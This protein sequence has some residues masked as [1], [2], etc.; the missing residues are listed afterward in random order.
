M[1]CHAMPCPPMVVLPWQRMGSGLGPGIPR[2]LA[3]PPP[4]S[5]RAPYHVR[6]KVALVSDLQAA[7]GS[8][9]LLGCCR[10]ST[11]GIRVASCTSTGQHDQH[12]RRW[13]QHAAASPP[14]AAPAPA[15][16]PR[17]TR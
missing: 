3:P 13:H 11:I 5:L 10:R 7:R 8:T 17:V 16:T 6:S 14:P 4:P 2:A 12:E 1:P 15:S 9:G